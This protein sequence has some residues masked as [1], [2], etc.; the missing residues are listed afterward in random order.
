MPEKDS[1][2]FA[3]E[4]FNQGG[5]KISTGMVACARLGAKAG[6]IAKIGGDFSG[7]FILKDFA[8]NGVDTSCILRGGEDTTGVLCITLS[9]EENGTRM[10]I[11]RKSNVTPLKPE[12]ID[13]SYIASAKY[14]LVENGEE[15]SHAAA[16]FAKE[17]GIT[18]VADGD[19]YTE[20]ME[21]LLPLVDVFIGSEYYHKKRFDN[22][23]IHKSCEAIRDMGP[24]TVWFTLGDKGCAGL[25]DND[26][27]KMPCFSVEV[28]DTTGAG[29]V[30]HG[31]YIVAM[32][33]GMNHVKCA[34]YASAVSAIKCTYVGG[35]TGIPTHKITERFLKDGVIEK[36]E[37]D[38][39]L[40]YYRKSYGK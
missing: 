34:E 15:Y 13:Y 31:A 11:G 37:L 27:H 17:R 33:N 26:F 14:L 19:T 28:R 22:I 23:S 30:F 29:D 25:V 16:T 1:E 35:R 18:V 9:E 5:G 32:M 39:R 24:Q 38:E 40:V 20:E 12:E 10:L 6:V 4:I 2:I 36:Q 8:Y 7:D 21:K 3:N